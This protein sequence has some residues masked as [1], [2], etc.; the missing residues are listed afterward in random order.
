MRRQ[1]RYAIPLRHC[2]APK[3]GQYTPCAARSVISLTLVIACRAAAHQLALAYPLNACFTPLVGVS[4]FRSK[5][6]TSS[7]KHRQPNPFDIG[8]QVKMAHTIKSLITPAL[9]REIQ[10]F[11]FLNSTPEACVISPQ[12]NVQRWFMGGEALDREC[13]YA[14]YTL[15]IKKKSFFF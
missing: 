2:D 11:W 9:L 7:A 12:E 1:Q 15:P 3:V 5:P 14:I 4:S 10:E 13:V 6:F 8:S